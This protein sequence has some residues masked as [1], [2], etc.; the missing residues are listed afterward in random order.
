MTCQEFAALRGTGASKFRSTLL[1]VMQHLS[2]CPRCYEEIHKHSTSVRL[3]E[4]PGHGAF[5][6]L[7]VETALSDMTAGEIAEGEKLTSE[8]ISKK[9]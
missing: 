6:R 4:A 9:S 1:E 7:M 5:R 3:H 2:E 8:L